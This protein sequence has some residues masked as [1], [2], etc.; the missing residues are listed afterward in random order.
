MNSP[1]GPDVRIGKL[2][3]RVSGLERW[4]DRFE[5]R[6]WEMHKDLSEQ[7]NT[8]RGEIRNW[9]LGIAAV[10]IASMAIMLLTR[11]GC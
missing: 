2:E 6:S 8:V 3:E 4:A 11:G 10:V 5:K 7:L 9:L 1:Q